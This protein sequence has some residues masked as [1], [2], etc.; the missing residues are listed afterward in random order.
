M[1]EHGVDMPDPTANGK[2]GIFF[3]SG[4][5]STSGDQPD[6]VTTNG[7][8]PES[9]EFQAAQEACGSILG[10]LGNGGPAFQSGPDETKP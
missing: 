1:R 4:G 5:G 6:K 7:I 9:P 8:D 3:R 10:T 2:G